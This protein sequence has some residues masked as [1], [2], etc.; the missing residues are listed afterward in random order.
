MGQYH[1]RYRVIQKMGKSESGAVWLDADMLPAYDYWQFWRNTE[2]GDVVRFLKLFTELSMGEIEKLAKLDGQEIN[3]AKIILADLAT[4]MCHGREAAL[5]AKLTAQQ[6]FSQH[7]FGSELPHY[8][9]SRAELLKGVPLYKL[10]VQIGGCDSGNEAKRL[11]AQSA[12]R[13]NNELVIDSMKSLEETD[14]HDDQLK[15]SVGKKKHIM[16]ILQS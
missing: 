14:F 9:I 7:E 4:E 1:K 3:E 2:D 8:T 12:V 16:V 5:Q 6:T 10:L 11:F 13:F 15:V